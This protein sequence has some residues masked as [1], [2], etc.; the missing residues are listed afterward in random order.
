MGT[1]QKIK[2]SLESL[3]EGLDEIYTRSLDEIKHHKSDAIRILQLL[4]FSPSELTEEALLDTTSVNL[5][6]PPGCEIDPMRRLN[7]FDKLSSLISTFIRRN[8]TTGVVQIAHSSVRDYLLYTGPGDPPRYR[9]REVPGKAAVVSV[10]LGF[11]DS[12]LTHTDPSDLKPIDGS[13][14]HSA[15]YIWLTIV[16]EEEYR[17]E[18]KAKAIAQTVELNH[19]SSLQDGS[20]Q[21]EANSFILKFLIHNGSKLQHR[22]SD[23]IS[24]VYGGPPLYVASAIGLTRIVRQLLDAGVKADEKPGFN[25]FAEAAALPNS[26]YKNLL[27]RFGIKEDKEIRYE[28]LSVFSSS[29]TALVAACR[30]GHETIVQMLLDSKADVNSDG[31]APYG[32]PLWTACSGKHEA[33][34]EMLL[35][36]DADVNEGGILGKYPLSVA[37]ENWSLEMVKLLLDKGADVNIGNPLSVACRWGSPEI[38]KVLLDKGP[39]LNVGV[40]FFAACMLRK[41]EIARLLLEKGANV[42]TQEKRHG[43][44]LGLACSRGYEDIVRVLL[45]NGADAN[46]YGGNFGPPL[47]QACSRDGAEAIVKLLLEYGADVNAKGGIHGTALHAAV[48]RG[49]NRYIQILLNAGADIHIEAGKRGTILE[50]ACFSKSEETFQLLLGAGANLTSSSPGGAR[51]LQLAASNQRSH[52]VRYLLETGID[53]ADLNRFKHREREYIFRV[54]RESDNEVIFERLKIRKSL[55]GRIHHKG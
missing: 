25:G 44:V 37:C 28:Q 27:H 24:G 2:E 10:C 20:V 53:L 49:R 34:V 9:F 5:E 21:K 26:F 1:I 4:L 40:P 17:N 22:T 7:S 47:Q 6:A 46:A 33:I 23:R 42:N 55:E 8:E 41:S 50:A 31:G 29:G 48:E 3:P 12:F 32:T 38:V 19:D 16:S 36:K 18:T 15:D 54:A 11:I 35:K 52:I 45:A 30:Q 51:I 14:L 39:D 13:W 43:T